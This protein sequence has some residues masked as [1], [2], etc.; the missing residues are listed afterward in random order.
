MMEMDLA[1]GWVLVW[2]LDWVSVSVSD[3][4]GNQCPTHKSGS[5]LCCKD[6]DLLSQN[7]HRKSTRRPT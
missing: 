1:L 5:N 6:L 4:Q 3:H 7:N 2:A